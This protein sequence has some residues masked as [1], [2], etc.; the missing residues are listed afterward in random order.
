L[1]E[2]AIRFAVESSGF[3]LTLA[4]RAE[5]KRA[6]ERRHSEARAE[7]LAAPWR[8]RARSCSAA[9]SATPAAAQGRPA[10]LDEVIVSALP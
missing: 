4:S 3:E 2:A 6:T 8:S 5:R 1:D 7:R 9:P 10:E